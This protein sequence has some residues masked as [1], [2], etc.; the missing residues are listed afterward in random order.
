MSQTETSLL[1]VEEFA[2]IP[3]PPGGRYELHHGECVLV[4]PPMMEH[5]RIQSQLM[6]LLAAHCPGFRIAMEF[7]FRPLP[8]HEV[9]VADV[10]IVTEQRWRAAAW[11]AFGLPGPGCRSTLA[12]E[13]GAGDQ[14]QEADLLS[15]RL[16][17]I[18]GA[19]PQ[20]QDNRGQHSGRSGADVHG[21]RRDSARPFRRGQIERRGSIR[22]MMLASLFYRYNNCP[23]GVTSDP[24]LVAL[25]AGYIPALRATRLD[26]IKVL[27][28]E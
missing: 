27:R 3:D 22:G 11:L 24:A 20:A 17:G 6:L 4:P 1:T 5:T 26:P 28:Y 25:A 21:Q 18:L 2:K 10:G 9:W 12:V 16:P 19:G 23:A 14:R 15:R 8:E 13:H 7:P